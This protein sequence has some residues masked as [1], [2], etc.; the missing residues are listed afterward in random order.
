MEKVVFKKYGNR[1]LYDTVR[2]TYVTLDDVAG[3]IREG[4]EVQVI[5]AR[6]KEDVTA[7]I[8]TQIILE[9]SRKRNFLL[10]VPLLHLIIRF[11]EN[12]LND[13]FQ[14]YLEQILHNY[15]L[16]RH[17]AEE[18][19]HSWLAMGRELSPMKAFSSFLDLFPGQ[20]Q[21]EGPD[22]PDKTEKGKA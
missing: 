21:R 17:A 11:G 4:Y 8:L 19:F 15:L 5:D 22:K 3:K 12:V 10:P 18:Q 2:S 16:Y 20:G 13:F 9:A 1:R 6:T 7:F 14:R